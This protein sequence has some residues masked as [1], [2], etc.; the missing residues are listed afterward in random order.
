MLR[1]HFEHAL[2]PEGV[3]HIAELSPR[4]DRHQQTVALVLGHADGPGER[5]AQ[6]GLDQHLVPLEAAGG[7]DHAAP[8][9]HAEIAAIGV[10]SDDADHAVILLDQLAGALFKLDRDGAIQHGLEQRPGQSLPQPPVIAP[11]SFG[12]GGFVQRAAD[13]FH[14][15]AA[16]RVGH[17]AGVH[18][19]GPC[20]QPLEGEGL[21]VEAAPAVGLGTG[22][23]GLI[24]GEVGEGME[25]DGR[26][27]R[28]IADQLWPT[29]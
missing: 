19:G 6:E 21:I 27:I 18:A 13:R 25:A 17:L 4:L 22:H 20:A 1:L 28:E 29:F 8:G 11:V 16:Q 23:I 10:F 26:F 3:L 12:E 7:D 14:Q 9:A 5:P 2:L 24:V 15:A